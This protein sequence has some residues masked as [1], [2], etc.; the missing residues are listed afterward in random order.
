MIELPVIAE[1]DKGIEIKFY[2]QT[3]NINIVF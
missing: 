2:G 3:E 1:D